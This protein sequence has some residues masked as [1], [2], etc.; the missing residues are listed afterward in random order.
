MEPNT[1][2]T[3]KIVAEII[4]GLGG[5]SGLATVIGQFV[6]RRKTNSEAR[7]T[8]TETDLMV[9]ADAA[10]TLTDASGKIVEQ[11]QTLLKDYQRVTD[12]KIKG[13]EQEILDLR[14][15]YLQRIGY[16]MSGIQMLTEQIVGLGHEPCWSPKED[17]LTI[18]APKGKK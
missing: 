7:K 11:Y 18:E 17:E 12:G 14:K 2:D 6:L 1:A 4:L 5:L 15:Q 3:L 16:L 10:N 8:D 13:L 9:P